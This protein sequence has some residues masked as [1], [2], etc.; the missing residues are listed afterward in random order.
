MEN[1]FYFDGSLF[2]YIMILF[3]N[4]ISMSALVI[5]VWT[6]ELAPTKWMG[7]SA[8]VH[9]DSADHGVKQV[10]VL[11]PEILTKSCMRCT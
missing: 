6:V 10:N 7:S 9:R 5:H 2:L 8:A 1:C 3:S 4:Q 11:M